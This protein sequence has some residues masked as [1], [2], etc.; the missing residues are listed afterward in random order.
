MMRALLISMPWCAVSRPN[1]SV[2]VLKSLARQ[3][4]SACD[5][6]DAGLVM[7]ARIGAEAY[8]T[9]AETPSMF[10]LCEHVF[11]C[12]IFGPERL[13][14]DAFLAHYERAGDQG[15]FHRLRDVVVP[16]FLDEIEA[17]IAGTDHP[18]VGFSCTFNQ[19]FASLALA[20]R[21]KRRTPWRRILLGG[22]C[23]HGEMGE[24]YARAFAGTVDHVFLGEAD[25]SFPLL[26]KTLAAGGKPGEIQGITVE[27]R[28]TGAPRPTPSMEAVPGPDY[29][30]FFALRKCL[31]DRGADLPDVTALP[32][33]GSRGCWWGE[34]H[35]CTFCGLN[36]L[37][38]S[39]RAKSTE[40][41]V[42]EVATLAR[43]YRM[44]RF[45]AADNIV[46]HRD[47][48][49]LIE[50]LGALDGD[51]SFFYEVKA[52]LK[53]DEV[54]ALAAA[55]VN[56][57]QPGIEAFSD[58][59]LKRME[60]GCTALQ[61]VQLLRLCAE[62]GIRP[63]YNILVGFP[64]E[65]EADYTAQIVLA[66][67]LAHLE[68]PS[69]PPGLVQIHRFS[70]FHARPDAFGFQGVRPMS[71]WSHLAPEGFLDAG[72]TAYF[73]DRDIDGDSP[74]RRL[75][76]ALAEAIAS[77]IAARDR[78]SLRL[79]PG[80]SEVT[81]STGDGPECVESLGLLE[82][83]ALILADRPRGVESLTRA[84]AVAAGR[85]E[86]DALSALA[87]LEA[88]GLLVRQGHALIS[89]APYATPQSEAA[90][91]RWLDRWGRVSPSGTVAGRSPFPE[92][93][94]L[95]A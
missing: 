35:H 24:E 13:A 83:A 82:T 67:K 39:F 86:E 81:R 19:V 70:P 69:G 78:L 21:I 48:R 53:R 90:L 87:S 40:R 57:I 45:M 91:S 51:F 38:M 2:G 66:G 80:F 94:A 93:E 10:G 76:P 28:K 75:G 37:G 18:V 20:R 56:W 65:T 72:R 58:A 3:A 43:R 73:F 41:V 33:E 79:G 64:G 62:F 1:L 36:N 59:Q 89:V 6:Y 50:R 54:A 88:R 34:K 68:A 27:G 16:A 29:S 25:H 55:G 22:A 60:K 32:Y 63:S 47:F 95:R 92:G 26:L 44:L 12:D 84:A 15:V 8:E 11:A 4:G 49:Q 9:L 30:D 61:N 74:Y 77:W 17:E 71:Y 42:E 46:T 5:V 7:A 31:L 23:V 52:N 85:G 14:S